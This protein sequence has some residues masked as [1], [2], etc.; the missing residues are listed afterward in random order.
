MTSPGTSSFAGGVI[1]FPS[2]FTRDLTASLA[3]RASIALPAWRSSQN[4]ITA[5]ATSSRRMM[6][7]SGQWRTT[8]ERMT[9]IS[10]IQGIGPQK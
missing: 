9:A 5:L 3:F 4:P 2:R 7:K 8:P 10:I 6:K 1:H